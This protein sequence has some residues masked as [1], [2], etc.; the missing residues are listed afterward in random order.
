VLTY[1]TVRKV[2]LVLYLGRHYIHT[3]AVIGKP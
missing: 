2:V 1:K 3:A